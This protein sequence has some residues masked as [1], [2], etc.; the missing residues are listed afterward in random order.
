MKK[1]NIL[2]ATIIVSLLIGFSNSYSQSI[3]LLDYDN[4]VQAQSNMSMKS[5]ATLKNFSSNTIEIGLKIIKLSVTEGH[6]VTHC[7][8]GKLLSS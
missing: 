1:F 6:V 2:F 5:Y 8:G 4:E 3:F 7:F